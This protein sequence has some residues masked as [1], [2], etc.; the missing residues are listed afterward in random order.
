MYGVHKGSEQVNKVIVYIHK[1]TIM[2]LSM[3]I[4]DD[5]KISNLAKCYFVCIREIKVIWRQNNLEFIAILSIS[6]IA[7]YRCCVKTGTKNK[8]L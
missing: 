8:F 7:F 3:I 6:L 2:I 1:T 4:F 5:K